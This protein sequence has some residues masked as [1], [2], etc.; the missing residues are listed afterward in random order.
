MKLIAKLLA[1]AIALATLSGCAYYQITDPDTGKVYYTNDW[2]AGRYG[3]SGAV[4][5][6]DAV[7][8][9]TVTLASS[10]VKEIEKDEYDAIVGK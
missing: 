5:F 2:M 7:S 8:G 10:E 6:K 9:S 4:T 1:V 3:Y